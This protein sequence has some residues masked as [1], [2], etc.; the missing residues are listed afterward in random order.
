MDI[1]VCASPGRDRDADHGRGKRKKSGAVVPSIEKKK[2]GEQGEEQPS[3]VPAIPEG[4][5]NG[6]KRGKWTG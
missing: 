1:R 2:E 5:M 6:R 3:L 4:Q